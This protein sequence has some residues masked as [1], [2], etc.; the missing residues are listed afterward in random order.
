MLELTLVSGWVECMVEYHQQVSELRRGLKDGTS[1]SRNGRC[2]AETRWRLPQTE[3]TKH[4]QLVLPIASPCIHVA[5]LHSRS[6]S[7]KQNAR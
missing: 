4:L 6:S 1:A 3:D 5:K 2:E 7:R